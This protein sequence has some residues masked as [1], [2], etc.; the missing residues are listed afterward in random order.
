MWDSLS[1]D[2]K[3]VRV[4]LK[5]WNIPGTACMSV[6]MLKFDIGCERLEAL[7]GKLPLRSSQA[8]AGPCLIQVG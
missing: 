4:A 7:A 6:A 5:R 1:Q 2:G 8:S 3:I